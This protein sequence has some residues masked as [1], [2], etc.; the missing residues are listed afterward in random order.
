MIWVRRTF[1]A[2]LLLVAMPAAARSEICRFAALD[3][4]NPFQRWLASQ[5]VTCVASGEPLAFPPGLWNVFARGEGSVSASPLLVDGDAARGAI[6]PELGPA[7]IVM[8][9]LAEGQKGVVYVPHRGSAFPVDGARVPVPTDETLWLFV[10][11]KSSPVAVIPIAPLA[12]GTEKTIDARSGGPAAV[13]GWLKVPDADRAAIARAS[14]VLAPSIHAGSRDADA[15]PPLALL[16]GAFFRI[17]DVAPGSTQLRLDG[18][19]WV[20]DQRVVNVHAGVTVAAAPLVARAAGTLVVHWNSDDDLLA[21]EQSVGSCE[22]SEPR[23]VMAISKWGSPRSSRRFDDVECTPIREET[24]RDFSGSMTLDDIA[25]G[26]YRAE[27]RFGKLPPARGAATVGPLRVADLRVFA[28]Y[29][30]VDGSV[31]RGGE[32]LG[33][34]VR[35]EFPGGVGFAPADTGEYHAVFRSPPVDSD[36]QVTVAACDGS[37]RAIVLTD[38]PILPN[39]RFDIDIPANELTVNVTDTFTTEPLSGASVKVEAVSRMHGVVF[40]TTKSTGERGSVAWSGVPIRELHLT[41]TR[42]GYEKH[43]V[44]PFT[45]DKS[46]ERTIGVQLVPQ[47]G[48]HG[49]IVSDRPFDSAMVMWFSPAGVETERADVT[50]DGTFV[51]TNWHAPEETM[52]VV[53]ASHPLWVLRTPK[54]ERRQ[55]ITVRY[56]AVPAATFDVWLAAALSP[57][58]TRYIGI[59][60]GG[61][62]VP[63][64]VLAQHQIMRRDPPLMNATGPQHFRDL[65]FTGPIDVLLGP[66]PEEVASEARELDFFALPKFAGVPREHFDP[67][68]GDVVFAFLHKGGRQP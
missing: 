13:I 41:V 14:G 24:L 56:P 44:E 59:E 53:S 47:R 22:E 37:T 57:N 2:L 43:I 35:I 40:T 28:S 38:R 25:P 39:V 50:P 31:T 60:I 64:P 65:L 63:Q 30:T 33:K 17:R 19:G 21:L 51:Y 48:T 67:R 62:R 55:G 16:H 26:S 45:M 20:P 5:D 7:A 58:A 42:A 11:D 68:S 18:H 3:A 9:L 32:P 8:P 46:G 36:T 54:V 52:S 1:S 12:A 15:L 23:L 10:L 27:L 29:F 34:D 49:K 6:A 61:V 4:E 66:A